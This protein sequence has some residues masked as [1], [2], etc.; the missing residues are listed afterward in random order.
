MPN[1]SANKNA[2]FSSGLGLASIPPRRKFA[3]ATLLAST[4]LAALLLGPP[5]PTWAGSITNP[6]NT[7]VTSIA[8]QNSTVTGSVT[9]AG[10]ITPGMFTTNGGTSVA[11]IAIFNGSSVGGGVTNSGSI[12]ANAVNGQF[13]VGIDIFNSSSVSGG[14]TVSQGG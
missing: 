10:T 14:L 8:I 9:N 4:S 7:V 6:A 13:G 2:N 12:R 5:F 11:A 1:A 3:P